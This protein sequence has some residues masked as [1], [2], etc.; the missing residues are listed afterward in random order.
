MSPS[1]R[2]LS[3]LKYIGSESECFGIGVQN[4]KFGSR[5]SIV[6]KEA[7][8]GL[9]VGKVVAASIWLAALFLFCIFHA[10]FLVDLVDLV[11][12]KG[13]LVGWFPAAT[14]TRYSFPEIP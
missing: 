12:N 11:V 6:G 13:L 7:S 1:N 3:L 2:L 5:G 14:S 4:P 8:S 9:I 10:G